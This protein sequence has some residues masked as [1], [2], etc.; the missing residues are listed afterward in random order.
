MQIS[1]PSAARVEYFKVLTIESAIKIN[2][3]RLGMA[4]NTYGSTKMK[5]YIKLW[6]IDLNMMSGVSRPLNE[7]Q[8][9]FIANNIITKY[10]DLSIA[11]INL[12]FNNAIEGKYGQFYESLSPP[13]ILSWFVD[14]LT[15]RMDVCESMS[16]E[17]HLENKESY[18]DPRNS[19]MT[20]KQFLKD[21]R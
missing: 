11:D 4:I 20:V 17:K 21:K 2:A 19:E 5:G 13:K 12:I 7:A 6:L 8:L 9:D 1:S 3:P 10:R 16:Y 15:L 18:H 14:Y